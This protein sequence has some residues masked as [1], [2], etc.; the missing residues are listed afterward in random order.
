[1]I[2]A[3]GT[4]LKASIGTGFK[5]PSLEE[6]FGPFGHNPNLKPETSTGYDIG[7]DQHWA[8]IRQRRRH[9]VPQRHQQPDRSGPPPTFTPVN[10]GKA[11]TQGVE[12]LS[13]WKPLDTLK[14]RADYT[15]TDAMTPS[16]HRAAA[17]ARAT[18]SAPN[19][20]LAGAAATCRWMPR[21][22]MP[23]RRPMSGA[24]AS[25]PETLPA[26]SRRIWPPT[27]R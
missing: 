9:L 20:R 12:S 26:M 16:P 23:G 18:R 5:A 27:T 10:I 24:K 4:R 19:A 7:L 11:R 2:D 8:A 21:C 22:F 1:M 15:Y 17:A 13:A 14:L 6:L 3:T 25:A